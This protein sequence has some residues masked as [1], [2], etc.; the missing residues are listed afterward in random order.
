MSESSSVPREY[1]DQPQIS[2][3]FA[4]SLE[5]IRFDG[6]T[7]RLEFCV[8]RMDDPKELQAMTGKKYTACRLVMPPHG[9]LEMFDKLNAMVSALEK[10]GLIKR[11]VS[12][13]VY[14]P[15]GGKAN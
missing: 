4:D 13:F 15:T 2:E 6:Q 9:L 3:I 12:P 7:L 5:R 11:N 14:P 1:V 8:T 10:Q